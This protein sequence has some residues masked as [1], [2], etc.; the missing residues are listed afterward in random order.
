VLVTVSGIG[1]FVGYSRWYWL[2]CW[3]FVGIVLCCC[4]Q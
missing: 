4:L 1:S 3:S 2:S